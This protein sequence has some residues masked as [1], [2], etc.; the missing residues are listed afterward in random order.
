MAQGDNKR[1]N[2]CD[3]NIYS[4]NDDIIPLPPN[5]ECVRWDST[6]HHFDSDIVR[7]DNYCVNLT[8]EIQ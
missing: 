3:D 4:I 8:Q 1:I 5:M 6:E 7:F 2:V